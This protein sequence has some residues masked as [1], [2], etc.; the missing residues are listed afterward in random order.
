MDLIPAP[1]EPK[2][3]VGVGIVGIR[4]APLHDD[5]LKCLEMRPDGFLRH[6]KGIEDVAAK[7][8]EGSD[9]VPLDP[10]CGSPEMV[11]RIMLDEFSHIAGQ[12]LS[13]MNFLSS[14]FEI[15]VVLFGSVDDGRQGDLL[16]VMGFE[17]ISD[18]AVV[19]GF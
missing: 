14:V 8:V 10:R 3:G 15:E 18:I 5:G 13:V 19:V 12:D 16:T 9:Q 7:V 6:E 17:S 11:G 2:D 1:D 4:E